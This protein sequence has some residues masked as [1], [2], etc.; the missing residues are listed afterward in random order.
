MSASA[1]S[2][3]SMYLFVVLFASSIVFLG[4]KD[5]KLHPPFRSKTKVDMNKIIRDLQGDWDLNQVAEE[6]KKR[7]NDAKQDRS[8]G[9]K[10]TKEFL[11][12]IVP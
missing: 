12:K 8:D 7:W 4:A 3:M 11:K 10:Q 6:R 1:T 9:W 2:R 5:L